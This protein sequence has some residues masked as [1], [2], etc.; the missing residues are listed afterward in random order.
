MPKF[1][2]TVINEENKQLQGTIGAP[3]EESAR[4]E[5]NDLGF[6]ILVLDTIDE[7]AQNP[8]SDIPV[9]E[10]AALDKNQKKVIGT[11]QAENQYYAFKRLISEYEFEIEYV[12]DNDLPEKDKEKERKK[13]SYD[14]YAKYNT[15]IEASK[16]KESADEKDMREFEFRQE[17]LKQQIDF[18]LSKVRKMLDLYEADMKPEVKENIRRSVEKILRIK[19]STNLDHIKKTA[20]E[21]LTYL[22]KEELFLH[23]NAKAK[24]RAKM[25]IEAKSMMMQLHKGSAEKSLSIHSIL[26]NWQDKHIHNSHDP[27][28]L[29]KFI[30]F[31]ITLLLGT[32]LENEEIKQ[33]KKDLAIVNGQLWQYI[34]LYFE[35]NSQEFK[36]ETRDGIKGLWIERKKIR[37]R[38]KSAIKQVKEDKRAHGSESSIEKIT[39]EIFSF[40]GWLLSFYLIYYFLSLYLITKDF[41]IIEV[42]YIFYMYKSSFLKYFLTTVFLLH[43]ALSLK[44]NFFKKNGSASAII[45]TLFL[46]STIVVYLNF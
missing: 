17:A 26:A 10:F 25:V 11:I 42:P 5:L 27:S 8:E 3:D 28:A 18:V 22:Q 1:R 38:L 46:V 24:E 12:V 41:G 6:S 23:E 33:L 31:F 19:S 7:T 15:E 13:G 30:N 34:K 29:E 35:A 39:H 4:K 2:Y 45:T 32:D 9:F 21:L 16:E 37:K 36:T 20:E 40:T 14:L 43:A 44:L